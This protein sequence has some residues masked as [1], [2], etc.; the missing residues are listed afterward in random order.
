MKRLLWILLFLSVA[1]ISYGQT[2]S[3]TFVDRCTG[4]VQVVT[5]NF[6][7][8]SAVVAFYDEAKLFTYQQFVNGEL[9]QWLVQKYA[10]WQALSPCSQAQNQA[11]QAQNTA[12]QA[13]SSAANTNTTGSSSSSSSTSSSSTGSSS[14]SDSGGSDGGG[15]SGGSDDGGDSG[16][17]GGE[18]KEKKEESKQEESK[19]EKKEEEKK[20]EES[21]EEEKEEESSEE[22]SEEESEESEEE[23]EKKKEKK[24]MPIQ[25][26]ADLM[27]MQ[28]LTLS[29]NQVLNIGASQTSIFGDRTYTANLMV[30]DNLKQVGLGLGTSKVSLDKNYQV[31]WVDGINLSYM[32]NYKMNAISGAL[33]RMKPLGKWGTVGAGINYSY[34]FGKDQFGTKFPNMAS[35]GYSLLYTNSVR[36]NNRIMY[37]PAIIGAQ[38]PITYMQELDDI[39]S[40]TTTSKD[41]IGILANS[42]TVQLTQKFSFNIAWTVIYSSNEYVP[43]MNSFMIGAKLPF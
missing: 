2:F 7:T 37:S 9:Q 36:I 33:T 15:S 25:L 29:Y 1:Q 11:T 42:F 4:E 14:G 43:I 12:T 27:S 41:F 28:S 30:W 8:G 10:W 5:A 26:K 17:S 24:L 21:K 39:E 18:G 35:L 22:E 16:S 31:S 19:E 38:N 40:L 13:T 6:T 3:Q 23:E 32:R 20:E 34:M